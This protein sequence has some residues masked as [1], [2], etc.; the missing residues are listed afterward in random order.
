MNP[1]TNHM[2]LHNNYSKWTI[3]LATF[4]H[5]VILPENSSISPIFVIYVITLFLF[6]GFSLA[7]GGNGL[8]SLYDDLPSSENSGENKRKLES[9]QDDNEI[10]AKRLLTRKIIQLALS[11]YFKFLEET[12][13]N[14]FFTK[15]I[16]RFL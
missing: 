10:P 3:Y 13:A 4:L 12:L 7:D 6:F 8:G 16:S 15:F 1:R 11:T 5:P 14:N 9:D 2:R